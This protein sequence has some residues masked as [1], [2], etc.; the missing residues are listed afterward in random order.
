MAY[1][2]FIG[3]I[4]TGMCVLHKCD[5]R[6]CVNPEHLML[7]TRAD[8][9]LDMMEKNRF[10][11]RASWAGEKKVKLTEEDVRNIRA[12]SIA[13]HSR[14]NLAA[15]HGITVAQVYNINNR[16]CWAKVA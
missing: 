14:V 10:K 4:P 3:E 7:G 16:K 13:G 6:K 1:T 8:N 5:N 9:T 12:M 11:P 2:A 15:L